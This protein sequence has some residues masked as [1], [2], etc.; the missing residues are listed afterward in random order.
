[1]LSSFP[2][3]KGYPTSEDD[4]FWQLAL[5]TKVAVTAHVNFNGGPAPISSTSGGLARPPSAQIRIALWAVSP[6]GNISPS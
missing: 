4:R 6:K 3:G 2:S 5:D 1:M